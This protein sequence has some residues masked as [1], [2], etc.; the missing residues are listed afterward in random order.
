MTWRHL[1]LAAALAVGL[2]GGPAHAQT[3]QAA[4]LFTYDVDRGKETA[5]EAAYAAHLQWHAAHAD[6]LPWFGWYVTS[7]P[8]TGL[9]VDGTFGVPFAAM[10]ARPDPAGDGADMEARVLPYAKARAYSAHVLWPEP[11]TVRGLETRQPSPAL[12]VYSLRVSPGDVAAFETALLA[13]TKAGKGGLAWTWY[14]LAGGGELGSYLV[15]VPR[16]AWADLAGRP[17][18]L[19]GLM[20]A[21]YGASP[22]QTRAA[23]LVKSVEVETWSYQPKLSRL[24]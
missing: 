8:R 6:T 23:D 21:A 17:A 4:F 5:F 18:D 16:R 12:D 3:E 15:L 9:F 2:A 7:G 22:D 10:D 13:S 19:A 11:S 14:R 24:P 20:A 1:T